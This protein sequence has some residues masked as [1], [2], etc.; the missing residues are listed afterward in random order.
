MVKQTRLV[1]T[2]YEHCLSCNPGSNREKFLCSRGRINVSVRIS[3]SMELLL[4]CLSSFLVTLLIHISFNSFSLA[5]CIGSET[6]YR[7]HCIRDLRLSRWRYFSI[8]ITRVFHVSHHIKWLVDYLINFCDY[9]PGLLTLI[10]CLQLLTHKTNLPQNLKLWCKA[11]EYN[12]FHSTRVGLTPYHKRTWFVFNEVRSAISFAIEAGSLWRGLL[13]LNRTISFNA[14]Y[15]DFL[16][17]LVEA[18]RLRHTKMKS[19]LMWEI[20][21]E[22][23]PCPTSQSYKR[24]IIYIRMAEKTW[25]RNM[26]RIINT[27]YYYL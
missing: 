26:E 16:S 20:D 19:K 4:S 2:L 27:E 22:I 18:L 13:R 8:S 12:F 25:A 5:A 14:R 3:D 24:T 17:F 23:H 6:L 7:H 21:H 9:I 10:E 11:M 1:F 15:K